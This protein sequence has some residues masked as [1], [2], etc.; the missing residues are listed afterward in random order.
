L[1]LF[2]AIGLE[3]T[4]VYALTGP[5][6]PGPTPL[7]L[8]AIDLTTPALTLPPATAEP[9]FISAPQISPDGLYI[10]G[11]THPG[12]ALIIYSLEQDRALTLS[13]PDDVRAFAWAGG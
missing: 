11:L 5:D 6:R 1:Q 8:V 3:P 4:R 7:T 9:G 2:D 13:T 10:A 12:G